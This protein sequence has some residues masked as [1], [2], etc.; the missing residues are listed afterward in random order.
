MSVVKAIN[1]TAPQSANKKYEM[2]AVRFLQAPF[3]NRAEIFRLLLPH[4]SVK[5]LRGACFKSV[6]QHY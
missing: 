6:N 5:F 2:D 1:R 3:G 4:Q